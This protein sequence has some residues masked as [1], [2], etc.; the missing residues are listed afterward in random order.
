MP[1]HSC[2]RGCVPCMCA[3][4]QQRTGG[5][6]GQQSSS[7]PC[8][9]LPLSADSTSRSVSSSLHS[10]HVSLFSF[11]LRSKSSMLASQKSSRPVLLPA[12]IYPSP[13]L[14]FLSLPSP[15]PCLLLSRLQLDQAKDRGS[16]TGI[17]S[18]SAALTVDRDSE[19]SPLFLICRPLFSC[20]HLSVYGEFV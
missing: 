7:K 2:V 4:K 12:L 14:S 13:Y 11:P 10:P 20:F 15:R 3:C 17:S 9:F 5:L 8:R 18:S 6:S 19:N 1:D 16:N